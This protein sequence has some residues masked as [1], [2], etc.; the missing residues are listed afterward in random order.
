MIK[1]GWCFTLKALFVLLRYLSFCPD[2]C[3][4]VGKWPGKKTKV[5]FKIFEVKSWEAN[6]CNIHFTQYLKK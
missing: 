2:F 4:Q 6:N 1:D 3:S 5:N